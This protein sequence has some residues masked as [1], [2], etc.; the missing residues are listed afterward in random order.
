MQATGFLMKMA[1]DIDSSL[2]SKNHGST[3]D[4]DANPNAK[5]PHFDPMR[6]KLQ[7]HVEY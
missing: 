2:L 3:M 7:I 5:G 4:A 6:R 1:K